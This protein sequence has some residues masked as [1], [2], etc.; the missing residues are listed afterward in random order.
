LTEY[1]AYGYSTA[2][3]T[4]TRTGTRGGGRNPGIGR[5]YN[6]ALANL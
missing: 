6:L 2:T 3:S 4:A 5:A 1:D